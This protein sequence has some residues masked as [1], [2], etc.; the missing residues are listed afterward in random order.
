MK[1]SKN[2]LLFYISFF[3]LC[4]ILMYLIPYSVDDT[5]YAYIGYQGLK[6]SLIFSANYGN[7][8]VLG[9]LFGLL[10]AQSR[11]VRAVVIATV[12][13]LLVA[14][15]NKVF[16]RQKSAGSIPVITA[17]LLILGMPDSFFGNFFSWSSAFA[18]YILPF[19]LALI[20]LLIINN[21]D[22]GKGY[23]KSLSLIIIFALGFCSQLFSEN[24]TLYNIVIP[25]ALL[26]TFCIMHINKKTPCF[27]WLISALSGA[28]AMIAVR[29]NSND[30]EKFHDV[31]AYQGIHLGS[32]EDLISN[33]VFNT[34]EIMP[35]ISKCFILYMLLSAVLLMSKKVGSFKTGKIESFT[36]AILISY[37]V[38]S[39]FCAVSA[40]KEN[41][42]Y[43]LAGDLLNIIQLIFLFIYIFSVLYFALNLEKEKRIVVVALIAFAFFT[44]A[45]FIAVSP[46]APRC[47]VYWYFSI[48]AV[49]LTLLPSVLKRLGRKKA[50]SIGKALTC[51]VGCI[52]VILLVIFANTYITDCKLDKYCTDTINSGNNQLI[53]CKASK[54]DYYRGDG[55]TYRYYKNEP[56]DVEFVKIDTDEW[57]E[58]IYIN[59]DYNILK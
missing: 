12:M 18:N 16:V 2:R 31:K 13:T 29:L 34:E 27:V 51:S 1:I 40:E 52:S 17:G 47:T 5:Y 4:A 10:L 23:I 19:F 50:Y 35:E 22:L 15:L 58:K 55:L 30:T 37:P 6:E 8:R 57:I 39:L 3:S 38:F 41:Y 7:G 43:S 54:T 56:G 45:P 11:L 42:Y 48:V 28:G 49:I 32:L 21:Y 20:C 26:M 25:F 46:I 9:N 59:R 24:S 14:L 33:T 53:I 36:K 44:L